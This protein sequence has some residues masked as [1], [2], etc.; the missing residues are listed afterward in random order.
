M[1]LAEGEAFGKVPDGGLV[2][3]CVTCLS[4]VQELDG[5]CYQNEETSSGF[6]RLAFNAEIADVIV[7]GEDFDGEE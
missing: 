6:R 5:T 2:D 7:V 3:C 4:R 1:D